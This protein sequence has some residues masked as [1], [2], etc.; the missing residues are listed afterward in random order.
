MLFRSLLRYRRPVIVALHLALAALSNYL[1]FWMR[2]DG[3]IPAHYQAL[4]A[5]TLPWLIA[6]RGVLFAPFRL[7]EGLWR[8][9]GMWDLR[10]IIASVGGSTLAFAVVVHW[11]LG[12]TAYPRSV[13]IVDALLLVFFLGGMRL[14]RRAYRD[15]G[16]LARAKGVLVFGAGDAGEMIVRDMKN[17]AFYDH[18]PI[19]FIDDDPAKVGL[20][21]HGVPVL[22]T[23]DDLASVMARERPD[24]VL[25]AMPRAEPATVRGVVRAL[26]PYKVR[27][28]TLPDLRAVLD[29][30]VTVSQIRDLSVED[31][32]ERAPVGF[33]P[34]PVRGF[35]RGR[36]VL[37]TGAGGSIGAELSRQIARCE[38]ELLVLLDKAESALYEIDMELRPVLGDTA[39]V[40]FLADVTS[41][42]RMREVCAR[43][44]P[45][46]V[47]HAA[48]YKHVPLVERYPEEAVVNNV[49]GTRR[50]AEVA[51][52][53]GVT[54]FVL[55]STDKA[56]NPTSV[57]GATK[58]VAELYVQA[59][60]RETASGPTS[61][62][63]TR[64]GNVLGSNGSVVPLFLKQIKARCPVTVT[65]P[66]M[67][68]YFMT[69][70]EAV[71][72]VLRAATLGR[73][74]DI[75]VLDMGEQIRIVDMAHH[76][77][78]LSGLVPE[79]EIP[80]VFTGLRPGE[81][82]YEELIGVDE[83]M[84][85]SGVE[86]ILRVHP[87]W[88]PRLRTLTEQ[89]DELERLAGQGATRDIVELLGEIVPTFRPGAGF[90]Q[91][92]GRLGDVGE[93]P[94]V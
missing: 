54:S 36:R 21:I 39:R 93:G 15:L 22:G 3:D 71:Q 50:L 58:R 63:V 13:L 86:G 84:E 68:R 55:I 61:F 14:A 25:V 87:A 53:H 38:P 2:F 57:M 28:T 42:T 56:V 32:L 79:E 1:A 85:P 6:I 19:G 18:R 77:I 65:H 59:F 48:A 29:G 16:P 4:W 76:L 73:G 41:L 74:G 49:V 83:Q 46:I 34:E 94:V 67:T 24:E 37:V 78:R 26:E 92:V 17:N 8:Y 11:G 12:M 52:E 44:R 45:D 9:T 30:R 35:V 62:C 70:P 7:Y 75:L 88:R 82:L 60:A 47:L 51:V 81:K 40:P 64:F 31:L 90:A 69:I 23:R 72:L 66:D 80:I 89:I 27:I 43:Y 33:D 5:T 20:R 91:P 10:N